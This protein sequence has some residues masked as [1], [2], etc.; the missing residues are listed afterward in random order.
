MSGVNAIRILPT[1]CVQRWTASSVSFQSAYGSAGQSGRSIAGT[2]TSV[3]RR[4]TAGPEAER[5]R[6]DRPIFKRW[7]RGAH[8]V[9]TAMVAA[10]TVR[11]G[12]LADGD[13]EVSDAVYVSVAAGLVVE[14]TVN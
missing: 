10:V 5:P 9:V 8:W 11:V 1:I 7:S 6:R 14:V 13:R 2:P 4:R 12:H 3:G